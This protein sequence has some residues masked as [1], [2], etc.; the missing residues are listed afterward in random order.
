M[1]R[2]TTK[3]IR[4]IKKEGDDRTHPNTSNNTDLPVKLINNKW[5]CLTQFQGKIC[6]CSGLCIPQPSPYGL[7]YWNITDPQHPNYQAPAPIAVD[8]PLCPVSQ[9]SFCAPQ[10]SDSS[11]SEGSS[12]ASVLSYQSIHKP[13]SPAEP[14]PDLSLDTIVASINHIISL[15][16]TLPLNPPNMPVNNTSSVSAPSGGFKGIALNIFMGDHSCLDMFWNKFATTIC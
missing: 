6:T 14:N 2:P 8:P 1:G 7:G 11:E 13:N 16:G 10:T 15:Q 4:G 5:Y 3:G 9:A 12:T